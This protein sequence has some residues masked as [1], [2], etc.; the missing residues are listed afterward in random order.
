M[1]LVDTIWADMV[2]AVMFVFALIIG[3]IVLKVG[4]ASFEAIMGIIMAVRGIENVKGIVHPKY[5]ITEDEGEF[6]IIV[7]FIKAEIEKNRYANY[8]VRYVYDFF[9]IKTILSYAN[10]LKSFIESKTK[11]NNY[12]KYAYIQLFKK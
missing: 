2:Y 4:I 12:A 11:K 3:F 10:S 7:S 1:V 8:C 5:R 9:E 6:E